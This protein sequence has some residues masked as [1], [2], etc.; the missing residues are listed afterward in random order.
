M[1]LR[2]MYIFKEVCEELSFTKTAKKLY[3]TQ[4][5]ISHVISDLEAEIG[6]KLFE[7]IGRKI[8]LTGTG[9]ILLHKVVRIIELHEELEN[10]FK[11]QEEL[12]TIRIGSSITIANF[13]LQKWIKEW[14]RKYGRTPLK[15][16]VDSATNIEEKL[17]NNEIDIALME[18][19]IHNKQLISH[20]VSSYEMSVI[21]SSNHD[22]AKSGRLE[23]A[24]EEFA[25][26]PL[27]LREKGSAIRDT[28]DSALLLKHIYVDPMMT[29]VNSQALIQAVKYDFGISVIPDLLVM[30]QVKEGDI[31]KLSIK[32]IRL[33][34]YN[35]ICYHRDKYLSKPM[36]WFID[37]C[38]RIK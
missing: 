7:R 6:G 18:G 37:C 1:N 32:D 26:Q 10:G 13:W 36:Q 38:I 35:S 29:S 20:E 31:A 30:Q 23:I 33:F 16:Q 21:C 8:H 11:Y 3:M 17:L 15:I 2:Q 9:E 12:V 19:A 24:A 34:N 5:A 22:F 27:L 14:R 25:A 4:P 28:L